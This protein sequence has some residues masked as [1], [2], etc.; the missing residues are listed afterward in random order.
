MIEAARALLAEGTTPTVESA[1]ARCGVSRATAY[2]YFPNQH[3]LLVA[4]HP[5]V[6]MASL[7]PPDPPDDPTE[8]VLQVSA[9]IIDL[10]LASEAELRMSLRLSL[11]PGTSAD[12]PLRKG[13]R[14]VWFEDALEPMRGVLAATAFRRLS[15][16]LA[17]SVGVE[18]FVWLT[19]VA[20]LSH[21]QA[22]QQLLWTARALMNTATSP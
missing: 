16:G 11:E 6:D 20:G 13:R 9:R 15:L 22:R 5:M 1:A 17:A 21:K 8:R 19:D 2:R 12:L 4:T 7:L 18:P 3:D 10:V 14:L